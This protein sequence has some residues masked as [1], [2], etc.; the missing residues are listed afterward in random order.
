MAGDG[1]DSGAVD[2][3]TGRAAAA[4]TRKRKKTSPALDMGGE[5]RSE[6]A[7]ELWRAV[8]GLRNWEKNARSNIEKKRRIDLAAFVEMSQVIERACTRMEAREA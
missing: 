7:K 1:S 4:D 6:A 5:L 8:S 2:V 3:G